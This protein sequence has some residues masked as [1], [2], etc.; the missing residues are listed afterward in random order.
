M[1]LEGASG[2]GKTRLAEWLVNRTEELG[3]ATTF[4]AYHSPVDSRRDGLASMIARHL[5]LDESA[6][7]PQDA[8]TDWFDDH[9]STHAYYWRAIAS[10]LNGS[11]LWPGEMP[12]VEITMDLADQRY[13]AIIRFLRASASSGP[14]LLHLDDLHLSRES[15]GFARYV[16]EKVQNFPLLIVGTTRREDFSAYPDRREAIDALADKARVESVQLTS[17]DSSTQRELITTLADFEPDTLDRLVDAGKGNPLVTLQTIET[18]IDR[19]VLVRREDGY[20]LATRPDP[21]LPESL[22]ESATWQIDQV[23]AQFGKEALQALELA[24]ALG[25]EFDTDDW[26]AACRKADVE[27][28]AFLEE[29][30]LNRNLLTTCSVGWRFQHPPFRQALEMHAES[31]GRWKQWNAICA[32]LLSQRFNKTRPAIA[33]RYAYH[34]LIADMPDQAI[35]PLLAALRFAFRSALKTPF[36]TNLRVLDQL[37][38]AADLPETDR[39]YVEYTVF[40]G[41]DDLTARRNRPSTREHLQRARRLAREGGYD[42]LLSMTL[43]GLGKI[44]HRELDFDRALEYCEQAASYLTDSASVIQRGSLLRSLGNTLLRTGRHQE[45]LDR[46]EEAVDELEAHPVARAKVIHMIGL[47]YAR[48]G[49][50]DRATQEILRAFRIFNSQG[51]LYG[52]AKSLNKIGDIER[53]EGHLDQASEYYRRAVRIAELTALPSLGH[54]FVSHGQVEVDRGNYQRALERLDQAF[55]EPKIEASK[56]FQFVGTLYRSVSLAGL[57]RWS[58][59]ADALEIVAGFPA[60]LGVNDTDVLPYLERGRQLAEAS[61][62]TEIAERYHRQLE[63]RRPA[64]PDEATSGRSTLGET[65]SESHDR[66]R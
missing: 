50:F 22:E 14:F 61:G 21:Q 11:G 10:I 36:R 63:L 5:R 35:Q 41:Y 44:H 53:T 52:A 51:Y 18:S 17:L 6:R 3:C 62:R 9:G 31:A 57:D 28:P 27:P 15:L 16:I 19:G 7:T 32:D 25:R 47:T 12:E 20:A 48:M 59:C 23:R 1:L 34:S 37:V 26:N 65:T 60:D 58:E 38:E 29:G 55:E 39:R 33:R 42:D 43:R 64:N 24:A 30:L 40:R 46:L 45:A 66:L 13:A 8:L 56:L 4:Q 2:L 49:R 54:V